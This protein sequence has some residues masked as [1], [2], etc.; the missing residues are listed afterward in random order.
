M[1]TSHAP[2]R[3]IA[4]FLILLA[5]LADTA[6]AASFQGLGGL[7]DRNGFSYDPSVSGNGLVVVGRL[8][9]TAQCLGAF[10]WTSAG[11]LTRL[12]APPGST[13][14][15]NTASGVSAGGE[16][17]VGIS[18]SQ[19]GDHEACRWDVPT[20]GVSLGDLPGG[21]F[22]S[23][24]WGVSGDGSAIV[25]SAWGTLGEEAFRWTMSTGMV[26]LGYLPGPNHRSL[27][28]AISQDGSAVVGWGEGPSGPEA[29][30]WTASAGMTGLGD[31]P[32]GQFTSDAYAVSADGSV[33]V[34]V[35]TSGSPWAH[36]EAFR[37]TRETGMV[38]LG[39]L[40]DGLSSS[41]ARAVSGDGE[42]IVG[43]DSVEPTPENA[44]TQGRAFIWDADHGMR[45]LQDVLTNALPDGDR[46]ELNDW[47]LVEATGISADG[48]TIVGNG[49]QRPVIKPGDVDQN[50]QV[51]IFDVAV[52]Q[53]KYGM[54]SGATW[55]DGD[56]DANGTVDIFD[57]ARLQIN[58]GFHS[59]YEA[60]LA[61]LDGSMRPVPEPSTL[62][63]AVIGLAGLAACGW[64]S[65]RRW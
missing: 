2:A 53:T 59:H 43:V 14:D 4:M 58:Y 60:W 35:S 18:D 34:G 7:G 46:K 42:T 19:R 16:V 28:R 20:E 9:S 10:Q 56:F 55:A 8:A 22:D 27:A 62:V 31:L 63:L 21:G 38:G 57:V 11:G 23:H 1:R 25:G 47:V 51:D 12:K 64:R 61:T 48:K 52:L 13:D 40:A 44:F 5:G 6:R 54:A 39:Y 30:L 45:E 33:V 65:H 17:I 29:F 3:M 41:L 37:W 15:S 24:A 32:G 50:C 36:G 49:F 26:G